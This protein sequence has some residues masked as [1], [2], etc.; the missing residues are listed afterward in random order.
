MNAIDGTGIIV[1]EPD[2]SRFLK[3]AAEKADAAEH[4]RRLTTEMR[5]REILSPA[6]AHALLRLVITYVVHDRAA[7]DAGKLGGV[8]KPKRGNPKS[9]ARV[10]PHFTV[11]K[12]SA[13]A[14]A[15][16]EAELG[17][18]PRRRNGVAKVQRRVAKRTGAD[19]FLKPV[20]K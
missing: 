11:M 6:N 20:A 1:E 7:A 12:E 5:D 16:I 18:A 19:R 2:W 17:L 3:T 9:I 14:A 15:S 8:A 4:W 13:A 10:S